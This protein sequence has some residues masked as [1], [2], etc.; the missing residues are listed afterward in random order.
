MRW[1]APAAGGHVKE[2][3]SYALDP[4]RAQSQFLINYNEYCLLLVS[5]LRIEH[6]LIYQ[7][8]RT[9]ELH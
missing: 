1:P 4:F 3:H 6:K 5:E 9:G 7:P 2:I 8:S